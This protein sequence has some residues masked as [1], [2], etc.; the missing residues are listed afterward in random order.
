MGVCWLFKFNWIII[1]NYYLFNINIVCIYL[2]EKLS[3]QIN[4]YNTSITLRYLDVLQ[5]VQ[6]YHFWIIPIYC[7]FKMKWNSVML[8]LI[9]LFFLLI[10]IV[11]TKGKLCYY[12]FVLEIIQNPPSPYWKFL[13]TLMVSI[14]HTDTYDWML[15]WVRNNDNMIINHAL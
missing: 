13:S 6:E 3:L 14:N 5:F 11:I 4:W 12:R 9:A 15:I 2:V 8:Q 1:N 10:F 7:N